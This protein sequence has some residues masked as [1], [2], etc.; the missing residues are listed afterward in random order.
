MELQFRNTPLDQARA[1]A[2]LK[3]HA[4]VFGENRVLAMLAY[5]EL[6][7]YPDSSAKPERIAQAS[8]LLDWTCAA[9]LQKDSGNSYFVYC[10]AA[11][12]FE[13]K[14]YE[15]ML[16]LLRAANSMPAFNSYVSDLNRSETLRS[17]EEREA[18]GK[19]PWYGLDGTH[20]FNAM[21][22]WLYENTRTAVKKYN[23]EKAVDIGLL[24]LNIAE[25]L[26]LDASS[27]RQAAVGEQ[28][29]LRALSS[30]SKQSFNSKDWVPL[31]RE[32][33]E[34]LDDI[35]EPDKVAGYQDSFFRLRSVDVDHWIT[36]TR[37][38]Q[39][40]L[41]SDSMTLLVFLSGLLALALPAWLVVI[42]WRNPA[43]YDS[44]AALWG[45]VSA[46]GPGVLF[47]T[48]WPG[49]LSGTYLFLNLGLSI[50]TWLCALLLISKQ[51]KAKWP[52]LL[53]SGVRGVAFGVLL[54]WVLAGGERA[55]STHHAYEWLVKIGTSKWIDQTP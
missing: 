12:A 16:K 54:L 19:N 32:F 41:S 18:P 4:P 43:D 22:Q 34:F 7:N 29:C 23:Q 44:D 51:S 8:S 14:K 40:N 1:Q 21:S 28:I 42:L 17:V 39:H 48:I 55:L 2:F 46:A 20:P 49:G 53:R 9:G 36:K 6:M 13:G 15:E 3:E 30:L 26:W 33:L 38:A 11:R 45:L 25:K 47:W 31:K 27:A 50:A 24:H 52:V 10:Q 5:Y 37:R 35:G